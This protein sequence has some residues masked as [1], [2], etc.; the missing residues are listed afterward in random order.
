[1]A[2]LE[3]V[4]WLCC[5]LDGIA[6]QKR[7]LGV[8]VGVAVM[9]VSL[10]E[11]LSLTR[12]ANPFGQLPWIWNF[13]WG[14][15]ISILHFKA[16]RR[17][18]SLFG[19]LNKWTGRSLFFLFVGTTILD[20]DIWWSY[21]VGGVCVFLA[22]IEAVLGCSGRSP[23]T[24]IGDPESRRK[25]KGRDGSTSGTSAGL[26]IPP[27]GAVPTDGVRIDIQQTPPPEA[28]SEWQQLAADD[29]QK[30]YHNTVSGETSWV[31]PSSL[32]PPPPG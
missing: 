26:S 29:G 5:S 8:V 18:L 19:F 25:M 27:M 7:W 2:I 10:F 13:L 6:Y 21:I 15:L 24:N 22:G 30:Y 32:P 31:A 1:M 17:V 14:A 11:L 9:A 4:R 3:K 12:W 28:K 16:E 23:P 20:P